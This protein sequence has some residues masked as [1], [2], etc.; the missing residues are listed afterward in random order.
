MK[1]AIIG[2]DGPVAARLIESFQLGDGPSV[3]AIAHGPAQLTRAARF[4]ID[5]RVANLLDIDSLAESL[6]GCSVAVHLERGDPALLKRAA[7]VCCRAA[8]KAGVR[9]IV[10]MSGAEVHGPNPPTGTD[11]KSPLPTATSPEAHHHLAAAERQFLLECRQ[12]ELTG[13]SLR[14]AVIYGPRTELI[15]NLASELDENRAGLF[16]HGDGICNGLYIDNLI[17]AI[18]LCLKA[19]KGAGSTYLLTDAETITWRE[20][21]HAVAHELGVPVGSIHQLSTPSEPMGDV[22]ALP[23]R[24]ARI[25]PSPS[26]APADRQ[27]P[28]SSPELFALQQST[29][30]FPIV[31][32]MKEL[33]YQPAVSVAEGIRRS[34]AWWRFAQGDFSTAA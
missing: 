3:A 7:T 1:V 14:P 2:S 25:A 5:L 12:L 18:R 28:R 11:E 33:G 32:A 31:R 6:S 34:V 8:A 26:L 27:T 19:K 13:Y 4:A 30:K 20:F 10:F 9:R 29:W 23:S 24:H 16:N 17:A 22:A 21:Y 15:A